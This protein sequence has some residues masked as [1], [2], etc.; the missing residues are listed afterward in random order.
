MKLTRLCS[1]VT[2]TGCGPTVRLLGVSSLNLGRA[3]VW[4]NF[5]VCLE[6]GIHDLTVDQSRDETAGRAVEDVVQAA[7][8][9]DSL[10]DHAETLQILVASASDEQRLRPFERHAPNHMLLFAVR[11]PILLEGEIRLRLGTWSS[12]NARALLGVIGPS[13]R[14]QHRQRASIRRRVLNVVL[15]LP[16]PRTP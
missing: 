3:D 16:R 11:S 12:P 9:R 7:K 4:P 15:L 2:I 1:A 13:V 14:Y 6:T 8:I 5:F 10:R